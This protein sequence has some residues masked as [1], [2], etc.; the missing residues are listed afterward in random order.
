MQRPSI[1]DA[2][3]R[4][5]YAQKDVILWISKIH[6]QQPAVVGGVFWRTSYV[7]IVSLKKKKNAVIV[8]KTFGISIFSI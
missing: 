2:K 1:H 4:H 3:Q 5:I 8:D 7:E 6:P